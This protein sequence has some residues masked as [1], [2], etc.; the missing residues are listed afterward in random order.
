MPVGPGPQLVAQPE[1]G[2]LGRPVVR[3]AQV[4]QVAGFVDRHPTFGPDLQGQPD[5]LRQD[6]LEAGPLRT[7]VVDL[8]GRQVVAVDDR[9]LDQGAS[10]SMSTSSG[11][12]VFGLRIR[13]VG[14]LG[15]RAG[16]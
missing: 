5:L 13:L 11:S 4:G 10:H 6:A 14:D 8:V 1:S 3:P 7:E 15:G 12:T 9:F 2:G 16:E